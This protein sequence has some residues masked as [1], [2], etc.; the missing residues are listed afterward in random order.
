[1]SLITNIGRSGSVVYGTQATFTFSIKFMT[2]TDDST[3]PLNTQYPLTPTNLPKAGTII[4]AGTTITLAQ[5]D[6]ITPMEVAQKIKSNGVTGYNVAI[7][8]Y[9]L[10]MITLQSTAI[11]PITKPTV[12]L[13]TATNII[14]Y[15]PIFSN[16]I[17]CPTGNL[18]DILVY[19][20]TPI[21]LTLATSS[22]TATVSSSTGTALEQEMG[23]LT[24]GSAITF[25]SGVATISTS[26]NYLRI[27]TSGV[28]ASSQVKLYITR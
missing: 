23:T 26:V 14:F 9:N 5:S 21:T 27:T 20:K 13:G 4:I 15:E 18:D 10:N 25:T 16:G 8:T 19:G 3:S 1:M 24:Y 12:A 22:V 17:S 2:Q 6:L 28:G 7:D 11:G